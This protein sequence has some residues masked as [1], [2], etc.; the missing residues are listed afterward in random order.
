MRY[1]THTVVLLAV[2]AQFARA[3]EPQT[4]L[5]VDQAFEQLASYDHGQD[6]TALRVLELHVGR[7]ATDAARKAEVAKRL[8]AILP[9]PD[10][11]KATKTFICK[12]LVI[13][14]TEAQV[15]VLAKMLD[16]PETAEIARYTLDAI[17]GE[18]SLAALRG[19]VERLKGTCLLGAIN[20][21]GVRR[22][23]KSVDVLAGLLS[24]S[25]A[26]V[27][28][29][30]AEALGKIGTAEAAT[31]LM[32]ANVPDAAQTVLH[33][34]RLQC[35][36]R[37]AASGNS[38]GAA[39]IYQ[40][41]WASDGP[42][43]RRV[44]GLVG[45]A[46][47]AADQATPFVLDLLASEDPLLRGTAV[48]LASRLPGASVTAALVERL[49]KL[50]P[51]GQVLVLDVLALRA[52]RSAASTVATRMDH[53]DEVVRTA[54]IRAMGS[55]GDA[56]T[57]E[58]LAG[59]AGTS[60]AAIQQAARKGLAM[61]AGSDVDAKLIAMAAAGDPAV[62]TEAIRALA[63]R[64]ASEAAPVL[65]KAASDDDLQIRVAAFEAL[66]AV[67]PTDSYV[68]LVEL[69]VAAPNANEAAVAERAVVATG[70]RMDEPSDRID[71]V[72]AA[73]NKATV[74]AKA[75]LLR[76]LGGFGG[77]EALDAVRVQIG[78]TDPAVRDAAVRALTSWPDASASGELL[79]IAKASDSPIHRVL[80]LR[81]YM[82]LVREVKEASTRLKMLDAILPI[83]TTVQ[84]KQ[85]LLAA[86]SEVADPGALHVAT[87]FLDDADVHA[88]AAVATLKI[89]RA[90]LLAD[91]SAVRA[92]M[93]KLM[94]TTKDKSVADQAAA[95]DEEAQ[96]VPSP[97]DIQQALRHD[98]KRSDAHKAT[99][100]KRAPKGCRL[101]CYLDCGPDAADGDKDE[102]LLRLVA[103]TPYIWSESLRTADARFGSIFFDGQLV[104][105]EATGLD[106][107]K[108]YQ[109]GF[110]WWDY[111]HNTRAQ[112][113]SLATGKGERE[114]KVLNKTRLPSG[115]NKQDPDEHTLTVPPEL[116]KDG[117]LRITFRNEGS[118]N[119][120]VS[121]LWLWESE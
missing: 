32:Q 107:K 7:F 40:Q 64:S 45:L 29:A 34:A 93:R 76:V 120:V 48:R 99:L 26:Q 119:V 38:A 44:A 65:I 63:A 50:D 55:L 24:N 68:K 53:E 33:N 110:T 118:P 108:A 113:V 100:A 72:V 82:R 37:L 78:S 12:Q 52:D 57:A 66:A 42:A 77:A 92:A 10:T 59:L 31:V 117:R 27:V 54:A 73:L 8:T 1:L 70:S 46:N 67:A 101:A 18:A 114:T 95:L 90:S 81:G 102:P 35:A 16:D 69:L 98:K 39:A 106:P 9:R 85:M 60:D 112:S 62:R 25:D 6:D 21:L 47:V 104:I 43:L 61:L 86:L 15:P 3:A 22:D 56:S 74:Q 75:P 83:A 88:E 79:K 84:A 17:P 111:D 19:A 58:R 14:G 20:T 96:R 94:D 115:A 13:V 2:L 23:A 11:S 103:G 116:N 87:K 28:T 121:E 109:I 41:V 30:T 5:S 4:P 97:S 49:E 105:F 36:E 51:T 89:A 71:P 91:P 80:A